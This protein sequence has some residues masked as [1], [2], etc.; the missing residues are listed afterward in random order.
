MSFFHNNKYLEP[1]LKLFLELHASC[2]QVASKVISRAGFLEKSNR[3][4]YKERITAVSVKWQMVAD[5]RFLLF[6]NT[7]NPLRPSDFRVVRTN[8]LAAPLAAENLELASDNA[9]PIWA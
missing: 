1:P 8:L 7:I 3:K 6:A 2:C 9:V 5:K 4:G